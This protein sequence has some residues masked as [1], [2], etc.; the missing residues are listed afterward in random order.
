MLFYLIRRIIYILITLWLVSIVSFVLI[1]L[2]PGDY[3]NSYIMQLQQAGT[4]VTEAEVA[5]LRKQYGLDL[6]IYFQYFKWI[7][8][9]ILRRDFGIS[10]V[11]NKP[12]ST[13]IKERIGFTMA[14]GFLSAFF[15]LVVSIPIGIYCATHQYSITDYIFTFVGYS[16]L[17]TPNFLFALL[18]MFF[19]FKY[20]GLSVGGLFSP[21]F[22]RASWSLAKF[23]DMLK[24]IW[25]PIIVLGT[26]GTCGYIRRMRAILLDELRKQYVITA[27]AKGLK[28]R[29]LIF[30]Y[31]VRV[32]INPLVSGLGGLITQIFGGGGIVAIVLAL[33]TIG[34]LHF[35]ALLSQDMYLAGSL[36]LMSCVLSLIGILTADILLV[37][38]DPRIKYERQIR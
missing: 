37:L 21:E 20:F 36:L 15:V 31:P 17:A 5:S 7:S 23:I 10:F 11:W 27:R 28:E 4:E 12:V 22:T 2:P 1:Q 8:N 16:G 30:K 9:I 6:P 25:I 33:P 34:P 32:A 29:F 19:A 13:L 35:R 38:I 14:I 18:L 3:L 26:A 24:H